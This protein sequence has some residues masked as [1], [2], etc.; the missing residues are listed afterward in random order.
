MKPARLIEPIGVPITTPWKETRP[1]VPPESI[2]TGR[3]HRVGRDGRCRA[4]KAQK[5]LGGWLPCP[6][7]VR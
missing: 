5:P 7:A 6:R 1:Y 2:C 4:C 3:G